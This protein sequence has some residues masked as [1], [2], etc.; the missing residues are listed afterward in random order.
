MT[1]RDRWPDRPRLVPRRTLL[2]AGVGIGS[3]WAAGCVPTPTY[4][5]QSGQPFEGVGTFPGGIGS[6][7]PTPTSVLLWTRVHPEFDRGE[8]IAV[9]VEVATSPAFADSDVVFVR[10]ACRT[11]LLRDGRCNR[12]AARHDLLVP[13]RVR[14]RDVVARQD[15]HCAGTRSER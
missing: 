14:G 15:P 7:D 8:G 1:D 5:P 2:G 11:R 13:V 4:P 10:A 6:A 12:A 3:L 9:R